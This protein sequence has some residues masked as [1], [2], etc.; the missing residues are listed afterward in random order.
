MHKPSLVACI[1]STI[2]IIS[3]VITIEDPSGLNQNSNA[4]EHHMPG[5]PVQGSIST[6]GHTVHGMGVYMHDRAS[7]VCVCAHTMLTESAD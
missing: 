7:L 4:S 3:K 5:V 6:C 2:F 1:F